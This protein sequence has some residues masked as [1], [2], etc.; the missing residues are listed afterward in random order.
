[1]VRHQ[2]RWQE[3]LQ[4]FSFTIQHCPGTKHGNSDAL[5]RRPCRRAGCCLPADEI[6]EPETAPPSLSRAD[7][8]TVDWDET[9]VS[10]EPMAN[11]ADQ[12]RHQNRPIGIWKLA[13]D[14][15]RALATTGSKTYGAD[16]SPGRTVERRDGED[17]E[18]SATEAICLS[19]QERPV[20]GLRG[21]DRRGCNRVRSASD[22]KSGLIRHRA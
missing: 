19:T 20:E 2:A 14:G 3:R 7:A 4:E 21:S 1:M 9:T 22:L 18:A 12:G 11:D 17:S 8:L 13:D 15:G 5:S 10:M 16:A 6:D